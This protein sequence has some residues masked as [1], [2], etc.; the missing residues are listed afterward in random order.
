MSRLGFGAGASHLV[1]GHSVEHHALEEELAAFTGRERALLFS[2]GYLANVG[3]VSALAQRRDLILA[4]RLCHA[5]L[6]DGGRLS[7]ARLRRFTHAD[8]GAAERLLQRHRDRD[9]SDG[10]DGALILTDGRLQHGR[11]HRTGARSGGTG[12]APRSGSGRR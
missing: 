7:G 8:V 12:G 6:L 4:D 2:S 1:T 10:S 5:S 3:V 9:E 11:R